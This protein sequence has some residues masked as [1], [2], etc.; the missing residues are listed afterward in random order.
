MQF[1]SVS[2]ICRDDDEKRTGRKKAQARE[3]Q[4]PPS[5]GRG[6]AGDTS[7][8]STPAQ[9]ARQR[10]TEAGL[11]ALPELPRAA[12]NELK[13]RL[14]ALEKKFLDIEGGLDSPQRD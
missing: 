12:P 3:P 11:E 7:G 1:E 10:K 4:T 14:A 9:A 2:F 5:K 13:L 8:T 6:A